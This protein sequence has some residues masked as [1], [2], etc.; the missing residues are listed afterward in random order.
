MSICC[1]TETVSAKITGDNKQSFES[2]IKQISIIKKQNNI[3]AVVVMVVDKDKV[4]VNEKM[5]ISS[6]E[7]QK[8]L[9]DDQ[10]FRIGSISK[11]FAALLTLRMQQAGIIN[12]NEPISK[13]VSNNVIEHVDNVE[14]GHPITLAHLLEHTA[15]L[16]DLSKAEWD[17]N[18]DQPINL[19][20]AFKLRGTPLKA[21]WPAG[22]HN[23]YSNAGTGVLGLVLE[24]AS[25]KSYENLMRQYVFSPLSMVSSTLLLEPHVKKRL[26]KGYNTD[27][28]TLIPYWHN[29]YRPFAAINTDDK[30]MIQFLQMFLN[31]GRING[32]T[33][34]SD[35]DMLRIENPETTLAA[36]TGLSYGYGLGNYQWQYQGHVFYGHGGDADGYLSRFGYNKPSGLAYYVMINAFQ[37]R[38]LTQI[39][40]LVEQFITQNLPKPHYPQRIKLNEKH[41]SNYVGEYVAVTKRFGNLPKQS[42]AQL[43]VFIKDGQLYRR[44][45]NRSAQVMYAVT[46]QHFRHHDEATATVAFIQHNN[47]WYLQGDFGNFVKLD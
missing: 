22:M 27:G 46:D 9:C 14:T 29:I 25:G 23:S 20:Q 28:K 3:S 35:K 13:Y 15:G 40:S 10:M 32:T 21:L 42:V 39:R 8:P 17:Y 12:I 7:H 4:L 38:S 37:H 47:Q 41:L 16:S 36:K 18:D 6:W 31:Q 5:G 11:S 33:F 2:L 34:F 26:M 1:L 44:F 19:E 24:K 43:N 45:N 30:D